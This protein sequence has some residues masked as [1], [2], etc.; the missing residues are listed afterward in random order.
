MAR[1]CAEIIAR[2]ALRESDPGLGTMPLAASIL[3]FD[4]SQTPLMP[5]T[6]ELLPSLPDLDCV[7]G[8]DEAGRG[9]LAGP[10]AAAAVVL[11]R[12][13]RIEGLTDSK[14]LTPARRARL[15]KQIRACARA[16]AVA[17]VSAQEIDRINILQASL[18]A[19]AEA[20]ARL[21]GE[22]KHVLVDGRHC[23][24]LPCPATAVIGGDARVDSISAASVL[25]K[26]ARDAWMRH[27]DRQ[28]PCYRFARHK[29]YPSAEHLQALS[30]HGPGRQH[31]RSYGP[32]R[33]VL[34]EQ[35]A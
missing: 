12:D 30:E 1:C 23:P 16:Y 2:G 3:L 29:G 11:P 22:V 25:A 9:A 6:L 13:C 17:F 18:C 4:L 15:A 33:A 32:V 21:P 19:M 8:V 28:E 10:V 27:C 34:A 31:R 20:V 14:K 5:A 26:E 7:A 24:E 35:A